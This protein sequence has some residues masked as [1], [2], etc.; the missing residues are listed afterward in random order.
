MKEPK[1]VTSGETVVYYILIAWPKSGG[2]G[3]SQ[4]NAYKTPAGAEKRARVLLSGGLYSSVTIR[5][6]TVWYRDEN[7]EFSSSGVYKNVLSA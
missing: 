4:K 3:I 6:E 5:K 7:N 1:N 2:N